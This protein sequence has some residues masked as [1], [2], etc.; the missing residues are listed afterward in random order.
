VSLLWVQD[1]KKAV[2]GTQEGVLNI[3]NWDEWGDLNDRMLGTCHPSPL[4]HTSK[5]LIRVGVLS[6][7]PQSID[8]IVKIDEDT[9]A[10][11]SSDGL[12]R[13]A[14]ALYHRCFCPCDASRLWSACEFGA[15]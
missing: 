7:H 5:V 8:S 2:V 1:G 11:G 4:V 13:Y 12:I 14:L 9:I 6:G 15:G 3:Y 10:T